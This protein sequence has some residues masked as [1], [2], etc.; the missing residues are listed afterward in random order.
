[1]PELSVSNTTTLSN[2]EGG[3]YSIT[4]TD[5]IGC[6]ST[7]TQNIDEPDEIIL[8]LTGTDV[9]CYG[10]GDGSIN[11]EVSGGT[12]F[13][14]YQW[15]NGASTQDISGLDANNYNVGVLDNNN[16]YVSGNITINEPDP[17]TVS[18][19]PVNISEIGA[20]DGA[21]NT[22]VFGGTPPYIFN[23]SNGS[24]SMN[25]SGLGPGN[26][27]LTVTDAN[28]CTA[29]GA[30]IITEPVLSLEISGSILTHPVCHDA[31]TGAI[32]ITITGGAG[33][34]TFLWSNGETDQNISGLHAG[35]YFVTITDANQITLT[36]SFD[37]VEPSRI[38]MENV[39]V[40]ASCNIGKDGSITIHAQGGL[41]PYI[42]AW[43]TT[44]VQTDSIAT[45][46]GAGNYNITITDSAGCTLTDTI[47]LTAADVSC[48]FIPDAFT[49][50]GDGKNDEWV[51]LGIEYYPEAEIEIFNRWGN[52]VFS[53]RGHYENDFWDGTY[54]NRKL[55]T[56]SYIYIIKLND[57][58]EPINGIVTII[59]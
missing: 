39:T 53:C 22:T 54:K 16:C 24:T 27:M 59:R 42:F 50:N 6:I 10:A 40:P 19:T 23:W 45:G 26:Y 37:I 48:L 13:Y 29:T 3:N 18:L 46:L 55:P 36:D 35:T 57:G 8:T 9:S 25:I 38:E 12:P 7:A 28:S 44:P 52:R 58:S 5:A 51:I 30:T 15:S 21:V 41:P 43:N 2:L 32:D 1:M 49:P 11:L 17:F 4:V 20:N 31:H 56:C 14:Q 47:I 33:G 34:Y